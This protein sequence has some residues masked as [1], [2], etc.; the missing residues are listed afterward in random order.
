MSEKK[1]RQAVGADTLTETLVEAA[2]APG[3]FFDN[4]F[5][6]QRREELGLR[7]EAIAL[8]VKRGA[9]TVANWENARATPGIHL[10]LPLCEVLRCRVEDLLRER[11]D[12]IPA[13]AKEGARRSTKRSGVPEKVENPATLDAVAALMRTARPARSRRKAS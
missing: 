13:L 3:Y 7:R 11:P 5:L 12:E 4:V 2:L 1:M 6:R 9:E 10:L 8:A